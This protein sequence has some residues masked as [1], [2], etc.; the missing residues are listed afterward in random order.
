MKIIL[1]TGIAAASFCGTLA[2]DLPTKAPVYKADPIQ[3]KKFKAPALSRAF[4]IIASPDVWFGS[5][6]VMQAGLGTS[7]LDLR[8][9]I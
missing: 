8:A 5:R 2:A 1:V 4:L 3:A 7:V 6:A 9:A